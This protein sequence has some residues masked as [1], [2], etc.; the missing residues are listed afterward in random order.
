MKRGAHSGAPL[1]VSSIDSFVLTSKR[2]GFTSASTCSARCMPNDKPLSSIL[3]ACAGYF[4]G[5]GLA[6]TVLLPVWPLAVNEIAMDHVLSEPWRLADL[7]SVTEG[8]GGDRA[9]PD[10]RVTGSIS[11]RS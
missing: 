8:R 2:R 11:V 5:R 9:A 6:F 1:F 4:A 10:H 3:L 7:L